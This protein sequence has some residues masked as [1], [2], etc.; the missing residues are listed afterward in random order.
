MITLDDVLSIRHPDPP[1]YS[2]DGNWL[3]F[4]YTIDGCPELWAVPSGGGPPVRLSAAG[5]RVTAWDWQAGAT[6][7]WATGGTVWQGS[8]EAE[9]TVLLDGRDAVAGVASADGR[10]WPSCAA[11]ACCCRRLTRPG[12]GKPK[13]QALRR[14]RSGHP[15][16]RMWR[17]WRMAGAQGDLAVVSAA[18]CQLQYRTDTP[19]FEYGMTWLSREQLLAVSLSMDSR[20]R[21]YTVHDVVRGTSELFERESSDKGLMMIQRPVAAPTGG[22]AALLLDV[23]GWHHLVVCDVATGQRTVALLVITRTAAVRLMCPRFPRTGGTLHSAAA[24]A[25]CR[26]ASGGGTTCRRVKRCN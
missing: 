26:S 18:D 4:T 8:P 10:R 25:S 22:A 13:C 6:A 12:S 3:G 17:A 5:E 19:D 20:H 1:R 15:T 11:A 7:V 24:R 9:P 2:P 23:D 21:D 16:A 14:R